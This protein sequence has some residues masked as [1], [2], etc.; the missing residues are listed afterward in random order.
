MGM[1]VYDGVGDCPKDETEVEK[2]KEERQQ[3]RQNRIDGFNEAAE[4]HEAFLKTMNFDSPGTSGTEDSRIGG[5][6][7][8]VSRARDA[9]DEIKKA[10]I[11]K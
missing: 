3:A 7:D 11:K 9:A 5:W 10:G 4:V 8:Y 6:S 1:P 2:K